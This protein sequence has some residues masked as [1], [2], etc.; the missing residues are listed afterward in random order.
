MIDYRSREFVCIGNELPEGFEKED[1]YHFF[2]DEDE[3]IDHLVMSDEIGKNTFI[4]RE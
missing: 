1:I 3:Y 2:K 4:M